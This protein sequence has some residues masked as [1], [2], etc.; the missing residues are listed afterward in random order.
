MDPNRT[1]TI[2]TSQQQIEQSKTKIEKNVCISTSFQSKTKTT[3]QI[4]S[5]HI[6]LENFAKPKEIK[7]ER[8]YLLIWDKQSQQHNAT[9]IGEHDVAELGTQL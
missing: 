9:T 5:Y 3:L 2:T 7:R 8:N 1:E 4:I 6:S